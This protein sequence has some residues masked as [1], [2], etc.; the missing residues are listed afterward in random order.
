MK[1]LYVD[2]E[3]DYG[4][5]SRGLNSIGQDGFK[6]SFEKL[7]HE[8]IPF[9]YDE[10]LNNTK[11]L[12]ENLLRF[13]DKVK[14]DLIFFM[15]FRDHFDINTLSKL[16]EKYTTVNWFGDDTWRF[17]NFTYKYA[18]YFTW[19]IT[20][21]KFSLH[22]YYKIGISNVIRSQWAAIN[23]NEVP[24][25][26][27][28]YK[29]D[30]TFVGAKHPYRKWFTDKLSKKG[31]NIQ[32]FGFG[33]NN[34]SLTSEQMND[35]F[36]HSKINLNLSNSNSLSIDYLLSSPTNIAHT[37]KSKKTM[38]QIKA[39]NFEIPYFNGFQLSDYVPTIEEYF[40]MGKE[41]VCYSN[42]DEAEMLIKYYLRNEEEREN[43]KKLSHKKATSEHGYI[44]RLKE[45]LR[46]LEK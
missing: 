45:F 24:K 22:K 1:I 7:G 33:W 39:R 16:K 18:P 21:D 23:T 36:C 43:I 20:T 32:C 28:S 10:Y 6:N 26:N 8:I 12:Q 29:Y 42:F 17:D 30:V 38:S 46:I 11:P 13:A 3:Y 40:D 15:I 35:V 4:I 41:I 2:I 37:I 5:K 31:I 25:F 27:G 19:S 44:N 9:Y 34:G 14:P